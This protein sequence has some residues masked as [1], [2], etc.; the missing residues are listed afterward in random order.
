MP[1]LFNLCG[2]MKISGGHFRIERPFADLSHEIPTR[3]V[4][5]WDKLGD[6]RKPRSKNRGVI[7]ANI[8]INGKI[9]VDGGSF[10]PDPRSGSFL[11]QP[12][13]TMTPD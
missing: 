10:I 3:Q 13:P 8:A 12:N 6:T 7:G 5:P 2:R 1:S 4:Q 9:T 11:A